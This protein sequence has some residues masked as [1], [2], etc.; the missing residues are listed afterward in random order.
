MRGIRSRTVLATAAI[1][2][3]T[4][5]GFAAPAHAAYAIEPVTLGWNP[6]GPVHSSVS[7]NGVVYVGGKLDGVGGIAAVDAGTGNLLW[8]TP[9][10]KDVRALALSAD[11]NTL[12][13]GG[14]FSAVGGV[15]HRH[16][17]AL[18]VSDGSIITS[19]KGRAAGMVRDLVVSGDTLYLGGLFT[20]VDGVAGQ[21]LGAVNA[22]T[23][24]RIATFNHTVDL[25]VMGLALNSNTLVMV[26]SFNSVD[27]QARQHIAA[28][29]LASNTLTSWAPRR[30][31]DCDTFWDV[32]TDGTYAYVGA[33]GGGGNFGSYNL[34]TGSARWRYVHADGDV[35]TVFLPGD[36]KAY[37]G[38]HFGTSI[39][40][41]GTPW[42]SVPVTVAAAVDLS[43]GQPDPG[44]TPKFYKTY[45]GGWAYASAGNKLWIGGDFTG[46]G[47]NGKNNKKP[48]LAAFPGV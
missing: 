24:A 9:A 16:L 20:S 32:Q 18:N 3:S 31:C 19:F 27:G 10:S 44:F 30:F 48:Y 29:D 28:I 43:T 7:G 1:T 40:N 39:F 12:Y 4:V 26:G 33:S 37:L 21:G 5:L 25:G 47:Q 17:V 6:A 13:A 41:T 36:G 14:S 11:G 22:T 38:G 35:Q 34:T 45:P 2:V 42:N 23:G 46:E 8:Q 15:T